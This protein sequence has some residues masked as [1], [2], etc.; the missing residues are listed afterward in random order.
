MSQGAKRGL[1]IVLSGPSGAGKST[2]VDQLLA[3]PPVPLVV[4]H[5]LTTRACRPDDTHAKQYRHIS[6]AEF[7]QRVRRG[8]LLEYAEVSGH[9][10]GTPREPAQQALQ[11]GKWLLL[12]IDVQGAMAVKRQMPEAVTIF[13]KAPSMS[14]YE[15]RLRKRGTNSEEEIQ[16]RLELARL[17]LAAADQYDYQVVNDKVDQAV[18][19]LRT[20]LQELA[21]KEA[22]NE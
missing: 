22:A 14:A 11:E 5:S 3:D 21:S 13:L 19:E 7:L 18:A 8:E 10:Y 4:S 16:R 2:V 1:L 9:L 17:E 12:E 15:Q 20:I 6:R